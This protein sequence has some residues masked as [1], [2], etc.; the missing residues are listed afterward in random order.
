MSEMISA[1]VLDQNMIRTRADQNV[2]RP[3]TL[4]VDAIVL[5]ARA[6]LSTDAFLLLLISSQTQT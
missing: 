5:S 1:F 6:F 4:M 2:T 3:R